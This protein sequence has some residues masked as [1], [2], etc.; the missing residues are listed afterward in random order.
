MVI[1]KV[2]P[3]DLYTIEQLEKREE[4]MLEKWEN[5]PNELFIDLVNRSSYMHSIQLLQS[6]IAERRLLQDE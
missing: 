1:L 2:N 3:F 6:I 4:E 5:M